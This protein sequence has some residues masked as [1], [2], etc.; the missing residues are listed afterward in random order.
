M[1]TQKRYLPP[2]EIFFSYAHEDEELMNMV[3]RQLVVNERNGR[4]LKWH[5]RQIPAGSGWRKQIDERLRW[6]K[7]ILL[8]VSPD[9]LD[10]RYCYE[11]EGKEALRRH[12]AGEA[13]VIPVILRPCLFEDAPFSELQALPKD[14]KPISTW[15]NIDEATLDV[16]R[17]VMKVVEELANESGVRRVVKRIVRRV[18]KTAQRSKSASRSRRS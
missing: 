15:N 2:V 14:A 5:D 6:A 17:G 8:F 18:K 12:E 3:R 1:A 4:I 7:I 16:A 13:T 9:F 10:S 11:V